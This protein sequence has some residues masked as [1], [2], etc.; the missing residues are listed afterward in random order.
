MK[1]KIILFVP[2]LVVVLCFALLGCQSEADSSVSTG[3]SVITG[4]GAPPNLATSN[5]DDVVPPDSS[6]SSSSSPASTSDSGTSDSSVA[7][8]ASGGDSQEL[9]SVTG[10]IDSAGMGKFFVKLDNGQVLQFEY[11]EANIDDLDDTRPGNPI[12]V[13]YTGTI[14]D[15]GDTS[16]ITVVRMETPA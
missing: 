16:G 1:T 4:G 14:P 12:T 9:Q 3:Q 5:P 11:A 8:S 10:V 7:T 13:Y 2:L 15:N 6:G